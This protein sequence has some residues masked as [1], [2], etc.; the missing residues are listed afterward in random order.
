VSAEL[1]PPDMD[2]ALL[3]AGVLCHF[4]ASDAALAS[5]FARWVE[6]HPGDLDHD[7]VVWYLGRVHDLLA[8][9][10]PDPADADPWPVASA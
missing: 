4:V 7:T 6:H 3:T 1:P 2:A 8:P 10:C 5:R 9:G